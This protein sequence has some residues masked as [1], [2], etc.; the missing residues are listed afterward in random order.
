MAT[1]SVKDCIDRR[2]EWARQHIQKVKDITYDWY[3]GVHP[4][5]VVA[6]RDPNS[7]HYSFR[8]RSVKPLS[9]DLP[10]VVADAIH[11]I[12][13]TMDNTIWALRDHTVTAEHILRHVSFFLASNDHDWRSWVGRVKGVIPQAVLDDLHDVQPYLGPD[14]SRTAFAQLDTLWQA[15]KHRTPSFGLNLNSPLGFIFLQQGH[16]DVEARK[17][18]FDE[19]DEIAVGRPLPGPEPEFE[20]RFAMDVAFERGGPLE[21]VPVESTLINCHFCV[22]NQILPRFLARL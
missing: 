4:Y 19:G 8:L 11:N 16:M 20:P 3:Q 6:E 13:A 14:P 1:V 17:G 12:R 15:S 10:F 22:Q 7:G 5:D 9:P 2:L 18:P 21:G